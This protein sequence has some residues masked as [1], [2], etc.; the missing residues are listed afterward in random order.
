MKKHTSGGAKKKGRAG[1]IG[2]TTKPGEPFLKTGKFVSV[3]SARFEAIMKAAENSGLLGDK[4]RRIGSRISPALVE[5]AKK[6][7]G[8]ATDTDLIE[9][10]LASV[11]LYDDF[12]QSF[13]KTRGTVDPTL[14]LG[15]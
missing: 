2:T 11:A 12:G 1:M 9:F 10:A 7:T 6:Q 8:I 14:K 5:K 4:S 3:S 13:R 15:F